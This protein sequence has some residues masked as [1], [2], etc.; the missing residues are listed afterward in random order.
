ME[1]MALA[2]IAV[3]RHSVWVAFA[4]NLRRISLPFLSMV[5]QSSADQRSSS[6]TLWQ[7][8][9]CI[10]WKVIMIWA[11]LLPSQRQYCE[12]IHCMEFGRKTS[13]VILG[14]RFARAT[15][16]CLDVVD[17]HAG[18]RCLQIVAHAMRL[19]PIT[20]PST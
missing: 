13:E 6:S 1:V 9:C 5:F 10:R 16:C 20:Q 19:V 18:N 7:L 11:C 14:T 17:V 3:E 2:L 12:R 4:M 15:C 8:V